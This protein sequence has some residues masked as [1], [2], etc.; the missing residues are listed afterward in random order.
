MGSFEELDPF[1]HLSRL[2]DLT[3]KES[4]T[5]GFSLTIKV[6]FDKSDTDND[7][8]P[9]VGITLSSSKISYPHLYWITY[10]REGSI[11]KINKKG[12]IPI[13]FDT[14][15]DT[16]GP[17]YIFFALHRELLVGLWSCNNF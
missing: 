4:K 8:F 9:G 6:S 3:K 10:F 5:F 13:L 2:G 16:K 12:W 11:L 15:T 17:P 14:I 7:S 1:A